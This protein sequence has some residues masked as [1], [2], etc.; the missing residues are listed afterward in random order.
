MFI[1]VHTTHRCLYLRKQIQGVRNKLGQSSSVKIADATLALIP[2]FCALTCLVV[3]DPL[4]I[5]APEWEPNASARGG[6]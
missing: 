1:D 5:I 3:V 6:C 4:W 2:V